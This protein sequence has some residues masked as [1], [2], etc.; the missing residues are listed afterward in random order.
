V[1]DLQSPLPTDAQDPLLGGLNAPQ[2]DAV[3]TTEGPVL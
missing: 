1:N 3:L 2:R